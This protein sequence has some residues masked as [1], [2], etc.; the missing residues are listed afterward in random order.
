[1]CERRSDRV[2]VDAGSR[3]QSLRQ[4]SDEPSEPLALLVV[5]GELGIVDDACQHGQELHPDLAD[6]AFQ[7][8]TLRHVETQLLART[9][10]PAVR[11]RIGV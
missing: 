5:E 7:L 11:S 6:H 3:A 8:D 1:M 2:A 4:R 9:V 10:G